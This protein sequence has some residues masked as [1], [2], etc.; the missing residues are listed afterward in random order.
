MLL[1]IASVLIGVTVFGIVNAAIRR[2]THDPV[3][4]DIAD[5]FAIFAVLFPFARRTWAADM[6]AC[7]YWGTAASTGVI[8]G[9]LSIVLH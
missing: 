2:Y 8:A 3:A 6:P 1:L 5:S 4:S 9:A 7:R